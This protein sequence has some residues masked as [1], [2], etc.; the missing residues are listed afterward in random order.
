MISYC[1]GT[2]HSMYPPPLRLLWPAQRE[3]TQSQSTATRVLGPS[4]LSNQVQCKTRSNPYT[5]HPVR[6]GKRKRGFKSTC[7]WALSRR[8]AL[9][10]FSF[11]SCS[12]KAALRCS[13]RAALS[14]ARLAPLLLPTFLAAASASAAAAA[15]AS[16]SAFKRCMADLTVVKC[17]SLQTSP[18]MPALTP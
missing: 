6:K 3:E 15:A 2:H 11:A 5:T 16:A 14:C 17:V 7:A 18:S 8:S 4:W 13:M 9:S 1:Y 12:A 10:S